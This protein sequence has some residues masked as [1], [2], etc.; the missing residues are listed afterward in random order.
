MRIL[1]LFLVLLNVGYLA[2]EWQQ[3]GEPLSLPSG[4][5]AV[6]PGTKTLTLL[7]ELPPGAAQAAPTPPPADAPQDTAPEA[8]PAE[9]P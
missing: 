7:S 1:F 3:Q 4:P 9:T 8:P 5:L 6:A 2:W